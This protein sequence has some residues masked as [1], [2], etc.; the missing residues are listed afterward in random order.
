MKKK[1]IKELFNIAIPELEN[2]LVAIKSELNKIEIEKSLGK[3]KNTNL[4]GSKK[5]DIARIKTVI[6][7]K[8]EI[9][10]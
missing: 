4:F 9:K 3:L 6:R 1:D 2:R 7:L 5:K 10:K 8:K